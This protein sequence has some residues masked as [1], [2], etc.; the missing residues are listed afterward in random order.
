MQYYMP[1]QGYT[2]VTVGKCVDAWMLR[3]GRDR[4]Y[5][6]PNR[7]QYSDLDFPGGYVFDPVAGVY[8]DAATLD[9]SAMYPSM[10]MDFNI[11]PNTHYQSAEDAIQNGHP[12]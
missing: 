12:K 6:F 1:E 11:G 9:Y 7:G 8:S 10:I 2:K 3:I 5:V 4:G